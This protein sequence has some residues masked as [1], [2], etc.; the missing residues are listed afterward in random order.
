[1]PTEPI[2]IVGQACV[3]PQALTPGQLWTNVISGRNCLSRVPAGRW[4][5]PRSAAMGTLD[6]AADKTWTDIGGY[7]TG[8]E[9]VFDPA[10]FLLPAEE[11]LALDPLFQW[12]LARIAGSSARHRT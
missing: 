2:A 5:V 9:S 6:D 3:L 4:G 7:V 1:M 11:I 12:M 10:G 8:F